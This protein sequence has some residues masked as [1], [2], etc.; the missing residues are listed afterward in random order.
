MS[1]LQY[2]FKRKKINR[3]D[4]FQEDQISEDEDNSNKDVKKLRIND[5]T[6]KSKWLAEFS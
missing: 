6:F 1:L 2:G 4:I 3:N 5:K